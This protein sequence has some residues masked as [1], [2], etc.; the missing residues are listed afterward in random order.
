MRILAKTVIVIGFV[1]SFIALI[2]LMMLWV[3][4]QTNQP[5]PTSW[6][7]ISFLVLFGPWIFAWVLWRR[8][9]KTGKSKF[10]NYV[11]NAINADHQAW[12]DGGGI[13]VEI[14]K[15]LIV[16]GDGK[17]CMTYDRSKIRSYG[18]H[19]SSHTNVSGDGLNAA[20]MQ[21]GAGISNY[22]AK[23][24]RIEVRD[25]EHP[26]WTIKGMPEKGADRW[27]EIINQALEQ[28]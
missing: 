8:S 20:A 16:V 7:I 9:A 15:G 3:G 4:S 13:A 28:G 23:G 18:M 26:V 21:V 25:V 27:T 2:F 6:W 19:Q 5:A 1:P 14:S 24:F 11:N 17:S 10:E 12:F 22:E